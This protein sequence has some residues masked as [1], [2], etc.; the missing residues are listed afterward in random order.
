MSGAAHAREIAVL[1][2]MFVNAIWYLTLLWTLSLLA[3][4]GYRR[5]RRPAADRR[6]VWAGI[7]SVSLLTL[8][9]LVGLSV[10]MLTPMW[11][12]ATSRLFLRDAIWEY[13]ETR[14]GPLAEF[15]ENQQLASLQ[16]RIESLDLHGL[17]E[18]NFGH[19]SGDPGTAVIDLPPQTV[20]P[21][22]LDP[23]FPGGHHPLIRGTGVCPDMR[24]SPQHSP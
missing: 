23:R 13:H 21:F 2:I 22:M 16:K 19:V 6:A 7:G 18:V 8:G 17:E 15:P 5:L 4:V 3:I 10:P 12:G 1:G 20:P 11:T 14:M 24:P 9:I